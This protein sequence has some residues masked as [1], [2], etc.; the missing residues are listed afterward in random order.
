VVQAFLP[1]HG[2]HDF[3][4]FYVWLVDFE[5]HEKVILNS[6]PCRNEFLR[7]PYYKDTGTRLMQYLRDVFI[8]RKGVDIK[9]FTWKVLAA[10]EQSDTTSCGLYAIRFMELYIG[11]FTEQHRQQFS[12]V[13]DMN[14]VRL[15]YASRLLLSEDNELRGEVMAAAYA[16]QSEVSK[17]KKVKK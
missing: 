14:T 12:D 17:S 13:N 9:D 4:H 11:R 7:K 6:I 5:K 10:P 1:I 3:E 15:K 16:F 2:G 8:E